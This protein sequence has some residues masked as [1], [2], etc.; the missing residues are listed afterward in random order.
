MHQFITIVMIINENK[1]L[2]YFNVILSKNAR[3]V[4]TKHLTQFFLTK[5]YMYNKR[6]HY[7]S[8]IAQT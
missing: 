6:L 5:E 1:V 8:F 7:N 2:D 3:N 4:H